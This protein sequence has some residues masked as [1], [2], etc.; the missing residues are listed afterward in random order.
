[1]YFCSHLL[2]KRT[3][4][5]KYSYTQIAAKNSKVDIINNRVVCFQS[6]ENNPNIQETPHIAAR[7]MHN[8]IDKSHCMH[9]TWCKAV[10][11]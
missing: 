9:D 3:H 8:I 5:S 7:L 2:R 6:Q 10:Q 11:K 4:I 1:M